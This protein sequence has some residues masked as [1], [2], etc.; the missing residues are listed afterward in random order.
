M[1]SMFSGPPKPPTVLAPIVIPMEDTAT[2]ADAK[3]R[4]GAAAQAASGR[5]STVLAGGS[6]TKLGGG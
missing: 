4:A 6:D 5:A 3:K 1:A 2:I